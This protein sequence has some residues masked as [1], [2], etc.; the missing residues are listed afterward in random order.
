MKLTKGSFEQLE[1]DEGCYINAVLQHNEDEFQL[2]WHAAAEIIMP[3]EGTYIVYV[4]NTRYVLEKNDILFIS[5]GELHEMPKQT[6][7]KRMILQFDFSLISNLKDFNASLSVLQSIKC[8]TPKSDPDIH[9]AIVKLVLDIRHESETDNAFKNGFMYS[10][11]LQIYVLIARKYMNMASLFPD[12]TPTKQREYTAKFSQ[13][14][15][16]INAHYT[17]ELTLDELAYHAGFSKFHF[18]RLFKQF[19]NKS[20]YDYLNQK[21]ISAAEVLLLNPNLSVTEVS[22]QAGFNSMSTFNRAFKNFKGCTPTEFK[23]L[24]TSHQ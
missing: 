6:P 11:L 22:L 14:F 4:N 10:K 12:V 1:F 24:Y 23:N 17:Q 18:S 13:I 5:I 15:A 9:S 20:L 3:T 2:H 21:R 8:I 19:T 16:Y 7:G